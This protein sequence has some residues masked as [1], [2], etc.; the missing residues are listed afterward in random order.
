M[1]VHKRSPIWLAPL[2]FVLLSL[3][4]CVPKSDFE[5]LQAESEALRSEN[6]RLEALI[7]QYAEWI[8]AKDATIE[9]IQNELDNTIEELSSTKQ[10]LD[11]AKTEHYAELAKLEAELE[12]YI[13]EL[14]EELELYKDTFGSIVQPEESQILEDLAYIEVFAWGYSDDADPADDG[15]SVLITFY[16]TKSEIIRFKN[17]PVEVT[18]KVYAYEDT[19]SSSGLRKRRLVHREEVT[20]DNFTGILGT[21]IRIP[22]E[23]IDY[24]KSKLRC[25]NGK[26]EVKVTTPNQVKFEDD[27]VLLLL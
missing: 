2:C 24:S 21:E 27:A 14:I 17:I 1:K 20:V 7:E 18:I 23:D 6:T 22:F 3:A 11:S 8:Q 12:T 4:G 16:D 9:E 19:G 26:I 10:E 15:I 13:E 25:G 5:E